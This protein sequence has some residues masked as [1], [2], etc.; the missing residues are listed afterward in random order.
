MLLKTALCDCIFTRTQVCLCYTPTVFTISDGRLYIYL[1]QIS[2]PTPMERSMM[3]AATDTMM[4]I[5]TGFCSLEASA[6]G[7]DRNTL[8]TL[9]TTNGKTPFFS[10]SQDVCKAQLF[11]FHQRNKLLS[12]NKTTSTVGPRS[13][14]IIVIRGCFGWNPPL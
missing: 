8:G 11:G 5:T 9:R 13:S 2:S 7:K 10:A 6:T 3:R 12:W 4:I 1:L 14:Q